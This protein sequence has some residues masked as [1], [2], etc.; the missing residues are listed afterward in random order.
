MI[1]ADDKKKS[2]GTH[3]VSLFID[4]VIAVCFDTSGIEYITQ[5]V[6]SKDKSITRNIFRIQSND[7]FL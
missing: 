7:T 6:L 2:K 5:Q 3:W 4:R 1:N